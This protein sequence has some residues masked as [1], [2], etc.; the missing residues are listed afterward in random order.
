METIF[1]QCQNKRN[2]IGK[3]IHSKDCKNC[4][5][6]SNYGICWEFKDRVLEVELMRKIETFQDTMFEDHAGNLEIVR[7]GEGI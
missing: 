5:K 2:K 3:R 1:E 6:C 4:L 7:V